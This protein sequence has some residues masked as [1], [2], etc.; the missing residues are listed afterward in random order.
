MSIQEL[1]HDIG[2]DGVSG[3][4]SLQ[5]VSQISWELKKVVET[6]LIIFRV[7]GPT[8]D[9]RQWEMLI[10]GHNSSIL[11]FLMDR[12]EVLSACFGELRHSQMCAWL[13]PSTNTRTMY[14]FGYDSNY[15]GIVRMAPVVS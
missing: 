8:P 12:R 2:Q 4:T 1:C 7:I 9:E 6:L 13:K 15:C 10:V 11:N 3:L 5:A 14:P